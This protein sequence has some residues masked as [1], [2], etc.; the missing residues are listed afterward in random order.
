MSSRC[1]RATAH[2][3]MSWFVRM[4][5]IPL[6]AKVT[7]GSII[8]PSAGR[9]GYFHVSATEDNAAVNVVDISLLKTRGPPSNFSEHTAPNGV[10]ISYDLLLSF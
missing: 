6:D 10:V 9:V 7:F 1:I 3:A 4:N 8:Q 5:N 2:V